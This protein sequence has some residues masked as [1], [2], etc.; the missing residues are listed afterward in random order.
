MIG[1][2]TKTNTAAEIIQC[3]I[4][5]KYAFIDTK[6][7]NNSIRH[8]KK[9]TFARE[10]VFLCSK[11]MGECSPENHIPENVFSQCE[12]SLHA[13]RLNYWDVYYIHHSFVP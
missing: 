7:T 5:N 2:G 9:C 11:L 10:D 8:F 4:N 6:D 1:F 3:A 12:K 13:A